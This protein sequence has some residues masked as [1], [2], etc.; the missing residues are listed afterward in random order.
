MISN[1]KNYSS[2]KICEEIGLSSN[3]ENHTLFIYLIL[4]ILLIICSNNFTAFAILLVPV[5]LLFSKR[6]SIIS[7]IKQ[8]NSN[9]IKNIEDDERKECNKKLKI[10]IEKNL[11][12]F[13]FN[14]DNESI[15]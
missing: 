10:A 6:L 14:K 5:V 11:N 15:N 4:L 12:L 3:F 7:Q 8:I 1:Y 2:N 9:F 13:V